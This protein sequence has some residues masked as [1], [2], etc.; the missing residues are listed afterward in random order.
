M[1]IL[2]KFGK[3]S[4]LLLILLPLIFITFS[5]SCT[6]QK[7]T[8]KSTSTLKNDKKNVEIIFYGILILLLFTVARTVIFKM[9][10]TVGG[11]PYISLMLIVLPPIL[12]GYINWRKQLR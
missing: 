1:K 3:M 11:N 4:F 5:T 10:K 7:S 9:L 12:A 8:S 2:K 6:F